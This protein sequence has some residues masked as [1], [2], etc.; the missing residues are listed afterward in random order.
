D[1]AD[2]SLVQSPALARVCTDA[3]GPGTGHGCT[4]FEG[5]RKREIG[6][7]RGNDIEGVGGIFPEGGGEP[8]GG[9]RGEQ[10]ADRGTAAGN[11]A[12]RNGAAI[13]GVGGWGGLC[14]GVFDADG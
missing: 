12:L 14:A 8:T 6:A 11:G 1:S 10:N 9:D 2:G 5:S 13:H 3:G 4:D 7:I